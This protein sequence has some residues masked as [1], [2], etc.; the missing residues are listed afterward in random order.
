MSE[1]GVK[2]LIER[3]RDEGVKAGEEKANQIMT[4]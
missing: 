2:E 4:E 3:L 1:S